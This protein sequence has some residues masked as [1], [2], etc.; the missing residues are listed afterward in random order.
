MERNKL[1]ESEL[2]FVKSFSS[3]V[4]GRLSSPK[5]VGDELARDHR[6]LV[7]E[8][9]KVVLA[10]METLALNWHLGYYDTRNEWS[11]K[12]AAEMIDGLIQQNLYFPSDK[13]K[14]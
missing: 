6:Y 7:Q 11:C 5:Q 13:Y 10:F 8:K 12:L 1:N 14:F 9:F 2:E 3:F 4:N